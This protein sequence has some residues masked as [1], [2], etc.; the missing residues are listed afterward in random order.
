M[1]HVLCS[2]SGQALLGPFTWIVVALLDGTYYTCAAVEYYGIGSLTPQRD[3]TTVLAWLASM[4]CRNLSKTTPASVRDLQAVALR[5]LVA[6]SQVCKKLEHR[7]LF[8]AIGP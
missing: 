2:L 4:P 3:N 6:H 5:E 7:D 8:R 1:V